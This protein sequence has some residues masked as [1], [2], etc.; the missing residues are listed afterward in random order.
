MCPKCRRHE[1]NPYTR[2]SP[3]DIHHI[4]GNR[5]NNRPENLELLCPNCHALTPNYKGSKNN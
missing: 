3:L 5:Q 4:D 1:I 2:K